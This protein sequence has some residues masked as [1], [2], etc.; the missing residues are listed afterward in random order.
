LVALQS[1]NERTSIL[2]F[3]MFWT[4]DSGLRSLHSGSDKN[5]PIVLHCSVHFVV[6][7]IIL[8][9]FHFSGATPTIAVM[10]REYYVPVFTLISA[11]E[12]W[13]EDVT[14]PILWKDPLSDY[15]W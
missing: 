12:N 8:L 5:Y 15:V 10:I 4:F 13:P 2:E 3:I 7:P 1:D 11:L 9:I 6:R 14:C